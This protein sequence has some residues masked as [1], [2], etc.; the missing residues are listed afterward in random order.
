M[1]N[2]YKEGVRNAFEQT[3]IGLK[4]DVTFPVW[5]PGKRIFPLQPMQVVKGDQNGYPVPGGIAW[6][7]CPGGP[8]GWGLGEKRQPVTVKSLPVWKPKMWP[9]KELRGID[10]GSGKGLMSCGEERRGEE[11][12]GTCTDIVKS[13]INEQS[14]NRRLNCVQRDI[15][16]CKITKWTK[17]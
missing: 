11:R 15:S 2:G 5:S 4:Y 13:R 7:P 8:P 12:R 9:R 14:K 16:K 6:P 3:L 17:K 1:R 10:I